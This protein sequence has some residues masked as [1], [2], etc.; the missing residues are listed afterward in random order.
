VVF[1]NWVLNA[2]IGVALALLDAYEGP[3]VRTEIGT[4]PSLF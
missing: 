2:S 3:R 1:K 4:L